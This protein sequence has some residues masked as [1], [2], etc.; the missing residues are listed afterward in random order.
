MDENLKLM[1]KKIL[2]MDALK[3]GHSITEYDLVNHLVSEYK[4]NSIEFKSALMGEG[5]RF[6]KEHELIFIHPKNAQSGDN[7]I[8]LI[9]TGRKIIETDNGFELFLQEIGQNRESKNQETEEKEALPKISASKLSK[10]KAE[11]YLRN[12]EIKLLLDRLSE[13]Y[14]NSKLEVRNDILMLQARYKKLQTEKIR[15]TIRNEDENVEH[16][17]LLDGITKL[18]NQL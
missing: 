2:E 12:N 5:L 17:R 10:A 9:L 1:C 18:I 16:C 14:Q 3:T 11:D 6:L 13:H 8:D 4:N 15:G 7:Y